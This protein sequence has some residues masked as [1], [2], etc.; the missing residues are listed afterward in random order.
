M[1][2]KKALAVVFAPCELRL[3]SLQAAWCASNRV[4]AP[5]YVVAVPAK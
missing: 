2:N 1:A 5:C 3:Q 4:I